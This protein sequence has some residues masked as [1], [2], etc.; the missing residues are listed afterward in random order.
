M[1]SMWSNICNMCR[2][3]LCTGICISPY[4]PMY[5]YA[6][7]HIICTHIPNMLTPCY[8]GIHITIWMLCMAWNTISMTC[9]QNHEIC[10]LVHICMGTHIPVY[11]PLRMHICIYACYAH[12]MVCYGTYIA[13]QSV[14][15]DPSPRMAGCHLPDHVMWMT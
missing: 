14:Y 10:H 1:I 6:Y 4:M 9:M 11:G 15:L 8:H 7:T 2:C 13:T 12:I 5:M 3:T